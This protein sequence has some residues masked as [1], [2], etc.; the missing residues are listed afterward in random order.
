LGNFNPNIKQNKRGRNKGENMKR[1]TKEEMKIVERLAQSDI[2][3]VAINF[4]S[5]LEIVLPKE[6]F[7][8]INFIR[9]RNKGEINNQ[10][11]R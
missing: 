9:V 10:T 6:V 8:K 1:I 5:G 11:R 3:S 2:V 7:D 4:K